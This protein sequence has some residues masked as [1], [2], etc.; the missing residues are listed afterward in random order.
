MDE[1]QGKEVSH[2]ARPEGTADEIALKGMLVEGVQGPM[3]TRTCVSA[4]SSNSRARVVETGSSSEFGTVV[5]IS[6]E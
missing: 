4:K 5:A 3:Q 6:K 1:G 2:P